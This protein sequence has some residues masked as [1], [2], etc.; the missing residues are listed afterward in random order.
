MPKQTP[1]KKVS[2]KK[3]RVPRSARPAVY[4][5]KKIS[6]TRGFWLFF[7]VW[8]VGLLSTQL[9]RSS[10]SNIFFSFLNVFPIASLIYA[11]IGRSAIKVYMMADNATVEKGAPLSYEFRI[12]NESI[13]PYPFVDAYMMLPQTDSVRCAERKVRISVPP[14]TDYNV[15]N[16]VSF[17]FRGT[18][19]IGVSCFY[20]Y[21]Y[22]RMFRVKVPEESYETVYVLPRKLVLDDDKAQSVSDSAQQTKKNVNSYEKIEVSDIR[23]YRPGDAIKS[24][25]WK[26]SSKCENPVI[27]E[28]NT[29]TTDLTYVFADM[30]RRFPVE[31][32]DKPF[33][34]IPPREDGEPEPEDPDA[35]VAELI[36]DAAYEDMNEYCADG[37]VEL[38][39]ASVLRELRNG[40]RVKL[41]WFDERSEI[42]AFSF[43]VRAE[44]DFDEVFRLFATAALVPP[45]KTVAKLSAMVNDAEDAKFI[46]VLPTID[47]ET[48][49]SICTMPCT[50]DSSTTD[51]NEVVVYMAEERY[52]HKAQRAAYIDGCRTQL[53]ESGLTLVKGSLDGFRQ[54]PAENAGEEVEADA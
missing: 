26:L 39:V 18:N 9:L 17:R 19:R 22:F 13:L 21:D 23:D 8:L 1:Q 5:W 43:E 20:V 36:N 2:K 48:V 29:G 28:Y 51:E 40:K 11:L 33:V 14:A 3:V 46:F 53:A 16:T 32:P 31:A 7:A 24:I 41:L 52:A 44:S 30:S 49:T 45:E 27:R 34:F 6:L 50:S 25:H 15:K 35:D 10:A 42:G 12:Y 47:D 38:A 4:R 54:A 37:V